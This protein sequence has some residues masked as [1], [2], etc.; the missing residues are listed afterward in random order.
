MTAAELIDMVRVLSRD[1]KLA[2]GAILQVLNACQEDVGRE[3]RAPIQTV[4]YG[5]VDS[6]GGL[7]WPVDARED[8]ILQVYALTLDDLGNVT[9]SQRVP[10]YDFQTA[11]LYHPNWTLEASARVAQFVVHDPSY[12]IATPYPVPPPSLENPQAFR[13]TYVVRPTKMATMADEPFNGR[14]DSFHDLLVY[15]AVWLLIRDDKMLAEFERRMRAA[16]GAYTHGVGMVVNPLY[17]RNV[18]QS[19]RG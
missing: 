4:L 12:E 5:N 13:V 16:R 2:D 11:S 14:L 3:L 15:R 19:G 17:A 7:S 18:I 9:N 10:V 6:V 1:E 8:G